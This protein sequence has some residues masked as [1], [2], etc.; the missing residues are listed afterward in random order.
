MGTP[1][2]TP[3][4]SFS[5]NNRPPSAIHSKQKSVTMCATSAAV[6]PSYLACKRRALP[7]SAHGACM[8]VRSIR[9]CSSPAALAASTT[10]EGTGLA[11]PPW[12]RMMS[13]FGPLLSGSDMGIIISFGWP[14][15]VSNWAS[16]LMQIVDLAV[17]GH[18]VPLPALSV[19]HH[20][21]TH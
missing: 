7:A 1:R 19:W 20:D 11:S 12:G 10:S 15:A 5:L 13:F 6:S 2:G 17:F 3:P 14:V 4:T 16:C 21:R 8:T 9:C 18:V